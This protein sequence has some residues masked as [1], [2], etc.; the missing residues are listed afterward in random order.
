MSR[1]LDRVQ[2]TTTST[3]TTTIALNGA[4]TGYRAFSTFA[5]NAKVPY[6]ITDGTNWEVGVGTYSASTL[7]RDIVYSS[8]NANALVNFGAGTKNVFCDQP[9][10]E[11]M[12]S[13]ISLAIAM[14]G[15]LQ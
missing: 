10:A 6:C 2:E 14:G 8:S 12:D 13:G 5:T 15:L 3:G 7:T 4:S 11:I 9:A 1:Y